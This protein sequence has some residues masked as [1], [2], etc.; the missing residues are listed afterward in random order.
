MKS[1]RP[2]V[3][4]GSQTS[5]VRPELTHT[6]ARLHERTPG[7]SNYRQVFV[8]LQYDLTGTNHAVMLLDQY[9]GKVGTWLDVQLKDE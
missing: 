6:R 7:L 3:V 5:Y 1:S 9:C 4:P 2:I 8:Q